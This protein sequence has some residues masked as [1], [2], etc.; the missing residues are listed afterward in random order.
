MEVFWDENAVTVAGASNGTNGSSLTQLNTPFD[1]SITNN[2]IMF[3]SDSLNH[4]IVV[5]DLNSSSNVWILGSGLGSNADQLSV[6][7][8]LL[9]TNTSLYVIDTNNG[10]IQ[11]TSLNGSNPSSLSGYGALN[12]SYYLY[13]VNDEQIYLSDFINHLVVLFIS[14]LTNG[15]VVAGTGVAGP[16]PQQLN[17][18]YGVFVDRNGT[19]Y[20]ADRFNHR[21]MKWFA[22]ANTGQ[23]VA[24]NGTAGTGRTQLY[25]PSQVIVDTNG[26]MYITESVNARI[27]RWAP[28]S[29]S[30]VCIA[31][32]TGVN[33]IATNQL[34]RPHSLAFDSH[35]SIYVN[36][37]I[38]NRIQKFQIYHLQSK[39]RFINYRH[40]SL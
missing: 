19:L 33:G 28:D 27:T 36:D 39:R 15:T 29:T 6:P 12:T 34:N 14:N 16:G 5:V 20:V 13:V 21:I 8:G 7:L 24:G 37:R 30:G 10:R 25:S 22:G 38:N 40:C 18:P 32:C 11:K 3:I 2:D 9:A 1:I 17:R 4:R 35:G 26:Y 31:A 23:M